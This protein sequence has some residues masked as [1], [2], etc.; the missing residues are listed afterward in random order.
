MEVPHC[1]SPDFLYSLIDL[2]SFVLV[3]FFCCQWIAQA[4]TERVLGNSSQMSF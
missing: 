1:P 3:G 4:L 2:G